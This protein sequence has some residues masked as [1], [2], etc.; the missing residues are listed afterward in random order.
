[1]SILNFQYP[2]TAL[3]SIKLTDSNCDIVNAAHVAASA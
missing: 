1:M 2:A 3:P